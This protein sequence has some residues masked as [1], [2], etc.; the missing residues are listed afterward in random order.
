MRCNHPSELQGLS[1]EHSWLLF[2]ITSGM[3]QENL[4]DLVKMGKDIA[5]TCANVPHAI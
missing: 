2:K 1:D 4:H 5:K 3:D